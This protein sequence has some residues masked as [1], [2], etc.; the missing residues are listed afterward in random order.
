MERSKFSSE[1]SRESVDIT[2]EEAARKFTMNEWGEA[3]AIEYLR[4][5]SNSQ[6][7][8]EFC[9]RVYEAYQEGD[10]SGVIQLSIIIEDLL[11]RTR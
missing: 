2:V 7:V 5:L 1:R 3:E 10:K 8:T 9:L 11:K 4:S 6:D